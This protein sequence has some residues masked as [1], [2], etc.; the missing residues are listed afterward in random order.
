MMSFGNALAGFIARRGRCVVFHGDASLITAVEQCVTSSHAM[1]RSRAEGQ[2]KASE[3]EKA[4]EAFVLAD[5]YRK[6]SNWRAPPTD[7]PMQLEDFKKKAGQEKREMLCLENLPPV[8]A[9][10]RLLWILDDKKQ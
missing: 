1:Y 8:L 7:E 6:V 4:M 3:D 9:Y 5:E 10:L 2:V